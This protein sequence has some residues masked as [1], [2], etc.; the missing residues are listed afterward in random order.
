MSDITVKLPF[1]HWLGI[2][3]ALMGVI[4]N[5]SEPT[6][7]RVE[8]EMRAEVKPRYQEILDAVDTQLFR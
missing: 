6:K 7:S 4:L 2:R 5:S 1:S 3:L 8:Q